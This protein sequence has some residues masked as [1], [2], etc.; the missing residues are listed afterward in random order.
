MSPYLPRRPREVDRELR[1]RDDDRD[2]DEDRE[3]D[4]E[5]LLLELADEERRGGRGIPLPLDRRAIDPP[6][7]P[8]SAPP[9]P[10]PVRLDP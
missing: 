9:K 5:R 2:R 4:D 3:L 1:D 8:P 6:S 10:P 7:M